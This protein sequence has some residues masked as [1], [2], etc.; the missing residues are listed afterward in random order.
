MLGSTLFSFISLAATCLAGETEGAFV[1]PRNLPGHSDTDTLSAVH[2]RLAK[3]ARDNGGDS[4]E[5]SH[6]F[7][8]NWTN[9]P[10]FGDGG[11]SITI[12]CL[13]CYI[14]G[15]V[16]FE[17]AAN[18]D[19]NVQVA[20]SDATKQI[21]DTVNTFTKLG[22][23]TIEKLE[24]LAEL[25]DTN[26]VRDFDF[27]NLIPA[28][29]TAP[30]LTLG[31]SLTMDVYLKLDTKIPIQTTLVLP[32]YSSP[33]N[34][35]F[36]VPGVNMGSSVSIDLILNSD[37][38]E[39]IDMTSGIH[40]KIEDG[41]G[42][43]L[44]MFSKEITQMKSKGAKFEF[45]PLNVRSNAAALRGMLRVSLNT[46]LELN[47][48]KLPGSSIAEKFDKLIGTSGADFFTVR[49]G[50]EA[51]VVLEVAEFATNVTSW[52][53]GREDGK[54]CNKRIAEEYTFGLGATAVPTIALGPATAF[55]DKPLS[56][57]PVF[58]TTMTPRC[59]NIVFEPAPTRSPNQKRQGNKETLAEISTEIIQTYDMCDVSN[60]CV[61]N[62]RHLFT[63]TQT[64]STTITT[65]R[66]VIPTFPIALKNSLDKR[67]SPSTFGKS[68]FDIK[69]TS[70]PPK[71][72]VESDKGSGGNKVVIGV[73]VGLVMPLL[74]GLI[75]A[76][77]L[78]FRKHKLKQASLKMQNNLKDDDSAPCSQ[79]YS[80]R[81]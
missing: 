9:Y 65:T 81:R 11:I 20:I 70:G 38:Y 76:G 61:G 40:L 25:A 45:L 53:G 51:G 36:D 2:R 37:G 55:D 47:T 6:Q 46:A 26:K 75:I 52:P 58:T 39:P 27:D 22:S 43:A 35:S 78:L 59:V 66:G 7:A 49:T 24:E 34:L 14:L 73:M 54:E 21:T 23:D 10:L 56:I 62:G 19:V 33:L 80:S 44:E 1:H 4:F 50:V 67:S 69:P 77:V 16:G 79:I 71:V 28:V 8:R 68:S 60:N 64:F 72:Y 15:S 63:T 18:E 42:F 48:V 32:L 41:I 13:D 57:I 12:T 5:T 31:M 30:D 74:I 29:S 17:M 3:Y